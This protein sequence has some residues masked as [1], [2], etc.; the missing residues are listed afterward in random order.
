[1]SLPLADLLFAGRVFRE[2]KS[3]ITAPDPATPGGILKAGPACATHP[4]KYLPKDMN[5]NKK[6]AGGLAR[7]A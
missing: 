3:T 5:M 2:R 4:K 6:P 1:M 7:Q